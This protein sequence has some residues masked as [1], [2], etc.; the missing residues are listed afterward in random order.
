MCTHTQKCAGWN[1]FTQCY[2]CTKIQN[3]VLFSVSFLVILDIQ[4]TF[5]VVLLSIERICF[6]YLWFSNVGRFFLIR[7]KLEG[8]VKVENGERPF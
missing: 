1:Y 5:I 3:P 7:I 4:V 6:I 2:N 8:A